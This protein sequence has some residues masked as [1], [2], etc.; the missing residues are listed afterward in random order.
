LLTATEKELFEIFSKAQGDLNGISVSDAFVDAFCLGDEDHHR[1]YAKTILSLAEKKSFTPSF[2]SAVFQ[3][4]LTQYFINVI[5][6]DKVHFKEIICV[7][8]KW[9]SVDRF[10]DK[11]LVTGNFHLTRRFLCMMV[12]IPFQTFKNGAVK[13]RPCYVGC[14][15]LTS[16]SDKYAI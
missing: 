14:C 4:L 15:K 13:S 10:F 12:I 3:S 9:V 5:I 7:S 1:C 8:V 6:V 11:L 2:F 16:I